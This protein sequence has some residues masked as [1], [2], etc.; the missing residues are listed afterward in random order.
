VD[1]YEFEASLV[2]KEF[3]AGQNYRVKPCIRFKKKKEERRKK[4]LL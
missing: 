2:F 4:K 3:Q 1:L